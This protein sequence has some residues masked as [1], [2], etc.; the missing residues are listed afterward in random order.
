MKNEKREI[1]LL[2]VQIFT[3]FILPTIVFFVGIFQ[4]PEKAK[5]AVIVLYSILI[6]A[7]GAY[8][9]FIIKQY[10]KN[11]SL[12]NR[13]LNQYIQNEVSQYGIGTMI[14][15]NNGKI[16]W[17]TNFILSRFGDSVIGKNIRDV[18]QI[19]E[20]DSIQKNFNYKK[21]EYEYEVH[22]SFEKNVLSVKDI[23]VQANLL[24]NFKSQRVV[25]GELHIDNINL[26]QMTLSQE[27]IYKI[28]SKLGVFFDEIAKK[29]DIIYHQY[30]NGRFFVLTT[31]ETLEIFEKNGFKDFLEVGNKK[32]H[33]GLNLT[34]S[35][36]FSY[37]SFKFETLDKLSKDALLQSKTRG[38]N[39]ITVLTKNEKPRFYGSV[40][41]IDIN[42]SRTN[43][44]Y[45]TN[46]L[47]NKLNSE[48]IEKVIVYGH[49]Q[50][51]LDALGSTWGIYKLA[52]GYNKT[53]YIQNKTF[54]ETTK[55]IY[56]QMSNA[57]KQVFIS[58]D[59]ATSLNDKN[60]LVVICDTSDETRIENTSA[61]NKI[62]KE[63]IIVID[64]H[65]IGLNPEYA[66]RENLY[67]DSSS[68]SAS[69][70]VT[71][72]IALS[73][74]KDKIDE[75]AAQHLLDGIYLDT[76]NFQK[77]TSSKTFSAA[78]LLQAWG[79]KISISVES[80]K[81][82]S[83]VYGKI[84]K[85]LSNLAEVKPGYFLA[86]N[87]SIIVSPDII[88][89]AA[90]EILRVSDRKAAFVV[91]KLESNRC[92]MSARGINTNVQVI[93]EIVNGGGHFGSAAAETEEDMELFVDNIKQA[94]VSVKNESYNN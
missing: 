76:N 74:N 78:A 48:N 13:T 21:D 5:I 67:I 28:Y 85:L 36:G 24:N 39:Q 64:H 84:K 75:T 7:L 12:S 30:D 53:A 63:N 43:V 46:V 89:M 81:M 23:T 19:N 83:E 77:Q 16:T 52:K 40:S 93:A 1:T 25:F 50:A 82:N 59:E 56:N 29:Y 8:L 71:E 32:I 73:N 62:E 80:L 10:L 49:K 4:F 18:F 14:F 65:R 94:I 3:L 2:I 72:I 90:D 47:I 86:Y 57:E 26:Y 6:I 9:I 35:G 51:D 54:D 37:G 31:H 92:K 22:V 41:E 27:E 42:M 66:F 70:I 87:N 33:K 69:E 45:I 79:A 61:F 34:L 91:G 55:K 20:L 58:P 15:L 60:T 17:A 44:A 38:G 88:S 11:T 68:S